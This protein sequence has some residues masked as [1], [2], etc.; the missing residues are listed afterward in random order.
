MS[1]V[2]T[3]LINNL[4]TKFEIAEE[5]SQELVETL[6]ATAF[7]I[8]E[9]VVSDH[10]MIALMIVAQQYGLNPWTKEIYAYPDKQN[11]I[12]PVVS[13]DGWSRI[14]NDNDKLD[15]IEFRYSEQTLQHKGKLAH[16]WIECIITR[17]DRTKPTVVREYF[18]E[19]CRTLNF[20][21]PWDTHP[22]RMHRHKALI[23]CARVAFGFGGIYDQ[24]EAERIVEIDAQTG[25]ILPKPLNGK[26]ALEYLTDEAFEKIVSDTINK[27]T[28]EIIKM[29]WRSAVQNGK[30]TAEKVIDT[31]STRSL[32]TDEQISKI[33][34]WGQV[35]EG[36]NS[37]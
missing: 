21:S 18:D 36:N 7:K 35:D 6:K 32:L 23:Q 11:G 19:V 29:R 31:I 10:Q 37:I 15:G 4:A 17:K 33:K 3:T 22:K 20:P 30:I 24:D 9:G 26:P 25:E 12:V 14:V 27:E 8:K 34:S 1:K 16:E 28:G 2:L 13:V 5:N